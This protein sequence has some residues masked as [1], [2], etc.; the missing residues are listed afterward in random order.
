MAKGREA[1]ARTAASLRRQQP[2]ALRGGPGA[3]ILR[4]PSRPCGL[5]RRQ[6]AGLPGIAGQIEEPRALGLQLV[7][8]LARTVAKSQQSER[9]IGKEQRQPRRRLQKGT[10]L[11]ACGSGGA[12]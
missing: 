9:V 8:E 4:V 6:I 3:E 5:L 2:G 11:M 7:D 10:A 12:D 1:A